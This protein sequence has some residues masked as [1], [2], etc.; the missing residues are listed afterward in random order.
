MSMSGEASDAVL[1]LVLEGSEYSLKIVG[2]GAKELALLLLAVAK[3]A[4]ENSAGAVSTLKNIAKDGRIASVVLSTDD[5]ERFTQSAKSYGIR[6]C[7]MRAGGSDLMRVA[8]RADDA[9]RVK[10]LC[11]DARIGALEQEQSMP[12]EIMEAIERAVSAP[13]N[14]QRPEPSAEHPADGNPDYSAEVEV[15]FENS[16]QANPTMAQMDVGP[17]EPSSETKSGIERLTTE[18]KPKTD[19][20][21]VKAA[22]NQRTAPALQPGRKSVRQELIKIH[23]SRKGKAATAPVPELAKTAAALTKKA[24]KPEMEGR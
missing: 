18:G 1:K 6:Y 16:P 2:T 5:F 10:M 21:I 17:S 15:H 20:P 9:P 22:E 24:V 13:K 19:Q 7:G 12:P 11:E 8:F 3:N 4:K 23:E 14:D